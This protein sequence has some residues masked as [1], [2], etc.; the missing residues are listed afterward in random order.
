MLDGEELYNNNL[1]IEQNFVQEAYINGDI[2]IDANNKLITCNISKKVNY[3]HNQYTK[4]KASR[5]DR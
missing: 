4:S 2:V 1:Q 5:R 3:I